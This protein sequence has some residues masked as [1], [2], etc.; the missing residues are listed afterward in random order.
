MAF[1]KQTAQ[2]ASRFPVNRLF[3]Y[4]RATKDAQPLHAN[5]QKRLPLVNQLGVAI[6]R[7]KAFGFPVRPGESVIYAF[8]ILTTDLY[9][10][11]EAGLV[12]FF[13]LTKCAL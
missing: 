12:V 4:L 9:S 7:S 8:S 1:G 10:N 5:I 11:D 13:F 3:S 2:F 6:S